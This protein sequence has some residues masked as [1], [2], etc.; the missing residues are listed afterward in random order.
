MILEAR[1][2]DINQAKYAREKW[3]LELKSI[4]S[5]YEAI[6][7]DSKLY[8]TIYHLV[9][10]NPEYFKALGD[11]SIRKNKKKLNNF[12]LYSKSSE[13]IDLDILIQVH[14]P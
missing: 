8:E 10:Q 13:I 12:T 14:F 5:G 9:N 6:T 3:D 7:L 1:T 11:K 2:K 4:K